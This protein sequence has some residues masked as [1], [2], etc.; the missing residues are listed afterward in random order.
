[1]AVEAEEF[2]PSAFISKLQKGF[3]NNKTKLKKKKPVK[4]F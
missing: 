3:I 1:M 2:Q 4:R